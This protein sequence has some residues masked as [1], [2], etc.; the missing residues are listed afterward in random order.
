MRVPA[1]PT[2]P[3][4]N[5][6]TTSEQEAAAF[7]SFARL[8]DLWSLTTEEQIKLLGSPARSTFFKWKKDGGSLPR[9]TVERISHLFGIY[10]ALQILLPEPKNADGWVRRPNRYFDGQSALDVMLKGQV[11]DIYRVR[12]YLDAQRGG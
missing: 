5:S 1:Q 8:A 9:D 4:R 10:K 2:S 12:Q 3:E 11:V 6:T 7:A